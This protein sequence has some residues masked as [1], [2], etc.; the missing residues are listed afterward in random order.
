MESMG[1]RY[2]QV[3]SLYLAGGF[4]NYIRRESA[5]EIGLLPSQMRDKIVP[6]GNAAGS[7][8]R[9]MLL[10]RRDEERAARIAADAKY[11]ELSARPDFQDKFVEN[12][13][14]E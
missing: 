9:R 6:V 12:M 11:I 1:I 13:M 8:A 2:G 3:K 10:S 4:G 5:V 14:F 7:G